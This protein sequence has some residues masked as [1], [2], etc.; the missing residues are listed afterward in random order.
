MVKI[1]ILTFGKKR[2]D[3]AN[4][5]ATKQLLG[6]S[7]YHFD[8]YN[9]LFS[10]TQYYFIISESL[11]NCVTLLLDEYYFILIVEFIS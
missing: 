2:I 1:P 9:S 3:R 5:Y 7:N 6:F 10:T 11:Y 4:K 8:E